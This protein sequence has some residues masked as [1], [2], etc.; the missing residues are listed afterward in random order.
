M[1]ADRS[2]SHG[3]HQQGEQVMAT[4]GTVLLGLYK[5]THMIGIIIDVTGHQ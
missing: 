5:G 1:V 2:V 4:V 3:R